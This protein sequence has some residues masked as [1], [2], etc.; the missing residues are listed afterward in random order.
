MSFQNLGVLRSQ[1]ELPACRVE[2]QDRERPVLRNMRVATFACFGIARREIFEG[3]RRGLEIS[4]MP[5]R[6]T[7]GRSARPPS[8]F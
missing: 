1:E 6:W 4:R 8:L 5:A 3:W 2:L 7:S